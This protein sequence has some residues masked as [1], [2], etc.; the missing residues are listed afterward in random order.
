MRELELIDLYCNILDKRKI[1]YKREVRKGSYHN[2][3]YIDILL[4]IGNRFVAIESKTNNFSAVFSQSSRNLVLCNYSY[5][6]FPKLPSIQ[7][8]RKCRKSGIGLIILQRNKFK[9]ILSGN[10]SKYVIIKC[11]VKIERNWNENR[12]GRSF[13]DKEI[14]SNYTKEMK[15]NLKS[16][17]E[18]VK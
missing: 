15:E 2:E 1:P 16:K 13:S 5:I 11:L 12:N 14:P 18:W 9:I 17:Y 6:L 4:N 8:I 3:G 10:K 7:N